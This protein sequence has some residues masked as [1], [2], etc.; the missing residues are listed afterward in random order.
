MS[1]KVLVFGDDASD[2][3]D[4]AWSWV[5]AQDWGGWRAEVLTAVMPP[6]GP[7]PDPADAAPHP[8]DPPAP[9]DPGG[10]GLSEVVH[11]RADADPRYVLEHQDHAGVLVVGPVGKGFLKSLHL[12]STTEHVL[13]NATLPVVVARGTARVERVVVAV[14]GSPHAQA[15]VEAFAAMPWADQVD[16]VTVV[17][18]PEGSD[19]HAGALERAAAALSGR[20]VETVELTPGEA[21][22]ETI[23]EAAARDRS[24][25][26]VAGT[27]GVGAV[28]R[29]VLGSTATALASHAPCPVLFARDTRV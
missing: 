13:T 21:V 24:Q 26:V 27:H 10:S 5:C 18:I 11:L 2:G 14:D 28:E 3:A 17:T 7:P 23:T 22:W 12:G 4:E 29:L 8:W 19:H 16:A 1:E 15:A 6:V 9:R 25:L 20:P